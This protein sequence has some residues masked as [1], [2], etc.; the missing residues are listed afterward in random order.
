MAFV[1]EISN[2]KSS[3]FQAESLCK[4]A[5]KFASFCVLSCR[6]LPL[7]DP[8]EQRAFLAGLISTIPSTSRRMDDRI[9]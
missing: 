7:E 9:N 6:M 3:G 4:L 2:Q 8:K 1:A 5:T